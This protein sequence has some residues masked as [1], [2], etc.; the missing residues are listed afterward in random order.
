MH[1]T[2]DSDILN[3]LIC[4]I[5][6]SPLRMLGDRLHCAQGHS[7]PCIDGIPVLLRN[8]SQDD[9]NRFQLIASGSTPSLGVD[10]H[11]E[12]AFLDSWGQGLLNRL[13]K[14][15]YIKRLSSYP[16][17]ELPFSP[18][19]GER[20]LEI[21]CNW[22]RW[23]IAAAQG[24]LSTVGIDNSFE[25]IVCARNIARGLNLNISYLVAD[26]TALPFRSESFAK[27][28]SYSATLFLP[29]D[30]LRCALVESGR[31]L[32]P[33]GESIMQM[34]NTWGLRSLYHQ[35]CR[36]F[37]A[38]THYHQEHS[39]CY[40]KISDLM[41][42][43]EKSIGR[44][45]VNAD[46]FLCINPQES[47][48]PFLPTWDRATIDVSRLGVFLSKY[49]PILVKVADTVLIHSIRNRSVG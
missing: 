28:F 9:E 36:G 43:F 11:V 41:E 44:S 17:P 46:G 13:T 33:G 29:H 34:G 20:L 23:C 16:I 49:F 14:G 5:D 24:G 25:A 3:D 30:T 38:P 21:G 7:Y 35:I 40:W 12:K 1:L 18:S 8:L 47:L 2:V 4:V 45:T 32:S 31:I 27:V 39:E 19:P 37:R 42:M 6:N 26:A 10:D 22:G 48:K 15:R